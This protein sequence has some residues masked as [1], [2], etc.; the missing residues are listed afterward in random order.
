M[1][2]KDG[3]TCE[4]NSSCTI[5][6]TSSLNNLVSSD[7]LPRL[8]TNSV[9]QRPKQ[10]SI[11][12]GPNGLLPLPAQYETPSSHPQP[13]VG[14]SSLANLDSSKCKTSQ[15][16]KNVRF[17]R[18]LLEAMSTIN[19]EEKMSA[20]CEAWPATIVLHSNQAIWS[21]PKVYKANSTTSLAKNMKAVYVPHPNYFRHRWSPSELYN[22]LS[23]HDI[24]RKVNEKILRDSSF[25]Y[26]AG[27]AKE[28][29]MEWKNDTNACMAPALLHPVKFML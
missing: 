4:Y 20:Q 12:K 11:C 22:R 8:T 2:G 23:M 21:D 16:S 14:S 29:Y 5:F 25:Y 10:D 9:E 24:Y 6:R 18:S 3:T 19:A 13:T 28:L 27:N 1:Y 7:P 17:S 15:Q 26:D